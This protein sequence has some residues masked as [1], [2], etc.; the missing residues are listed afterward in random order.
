LGTSTGN[1]ARITDNGESSEESRRGRC[2]GIAATKGNHCIA[3]RCP[4]GN[5]YPR[6]SRQAVSRVR[7]RRDARTAALRVVGRSQLLD[8][9][10]KSSLGED[11]VQHLVEPM[12][13]RGRQMPGATRN[14]LTPAVGTFQ[15]QGRPPSP[16]ENPSDARRCWAQFKRGKQGQGFSTDCQPAKPTPSHDAVRGVNAGES[17]PS[18]SQSAPGPGTRGSSAGS[19][20]RICSISVACVLFRPPVFSTGWPKNPRE[21]IFLSL[22]RLF[23]DS[24]HV[25]LTAPG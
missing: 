6:S 9:P 7:A 17:A 11:P 18:D 24:V 14:P 13:G 15:S 19:G 1:R 3:R 10:V 22:S 20:R 2:P 21:Q 4:A 16:Q 5:Q 12:A 25:H 23:F 8:P